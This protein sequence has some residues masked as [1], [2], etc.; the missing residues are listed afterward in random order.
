V[1][2]VPS[3]GQPTTRIVVVGGAQSHG[4]PSEHDDGAETESGGWDD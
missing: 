3:G 2:A 4:E 1:P